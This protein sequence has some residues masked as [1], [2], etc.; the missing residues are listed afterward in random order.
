MTLLPKAWLHRENDERPA[1]ISA[2]TVD[3]PFCGASLTSVVGPRLFPGHGCPCGAR[4]VRLARTGFA[5]TPP[6]VLAEAVRELRRKMAE[7][8]EGHERTVA[9]LAL[10]TARHLHLGGRQRGL[11]IG[12]SGTG[13]TTL[14]VALAEALGCPAIVWDVS[15]SSE[16]GWSGISLSDIL[17]EMYSAYDQD[18]TWMARG[19]LIA[20]EIDKLAVRTATGNSREHRLGQQKTLLGLLG[21]GAPVRFQEDRDRGTPLSIR[22][23]NMLVLAMGTFQDLPEDPGPMELVS[24][25]FSVEFASRWSVVLTMPSLSRE[26]LVSVLRREITPAL[27][28]AAQFG[29]S[30]RVPDPVL[31]YVATVLLAATDEVT[32]RAGAGWLVS[33]IDDTLLRLIDLGARPGQSVDLRPDDVPVPRSLRGT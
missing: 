7:V 19:I 28:A 31:A 16:A 11:L 32:P 13:K 6:N 9:R 8:V 1:V 5:Q 18:L 30:I 14:A 25:G 27:E 4:V 3:C 21:G 23:D 22:T 10:M 29:F 15:V 17:A 2:I 26:A 20:D 24:Y 12:P 33:A